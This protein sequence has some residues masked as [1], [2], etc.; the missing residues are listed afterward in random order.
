MAGQV[1]V[2]LW[3]AVH[4]LIADGGEGVEGEG[5]LGLRALHQKSVAVRRPLAVLRHSGRPG[6]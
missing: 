3:P 5:I 6:A 4:T 1:R 2:H